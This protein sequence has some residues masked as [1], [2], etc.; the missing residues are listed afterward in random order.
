MSINILAITVFKLNFMIFL[1]SFHRISCFLIKVNKPLSFL[2]PTSLCPF[3]MSSAAFFDDK[4]NFLFLCLKLPAVPLQRDGESSTVRKFA[5]FRF[6]VALGA[7]GSGH[8]NLLIF[9]D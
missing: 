5:I 8:A 4:T 7:L 6:A 9:M 1:P 2:S 3:A